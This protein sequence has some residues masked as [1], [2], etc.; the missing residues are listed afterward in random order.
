MVRFSGDSDDGDDAPAEFLNLFKKIQLK[1]RI[2]YR[3][4][5]ESFV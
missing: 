3:E 1:I 2:E 4:C 5:A